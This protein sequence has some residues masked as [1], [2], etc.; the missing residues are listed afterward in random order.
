MR[1]V[2]LLAWYD[3]DPVWLREAVASA[4]GL[5]DE[6]VALDGAYKGFP[7]RSS[8]SSADQFDAIR[9]A[10]GHP[11]PIGTWLGC[12]INQMEKRTELFELGR[13]HD[14]DWFL[15]FDADDVVTHV[16]FDARDRL[17]HAN[18]DVG[19]FTLGSDRYHRGL[20][21]SLPNLRVEDA[22]YHYLAEKD[23]RTV[24]LR[25]DTNVHDLEG[26]VNL[27]DLKVAHRRDE[28]SP[29]R[30]AA[31]MEYRQRVSAEGIEAT[32]PEQWRRVAV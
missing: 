4:L 30:K 18:E 3:E 7:G 26:F 10:G 31:I 1:I 23:G 11:Y 25:G 14:A 24:H 27:T 17:E 5:C 9:E 13:E 8:R 20:F 21:R 22:H 32:T 19:V 12:W 2:G 28:R 29:E 16:P 15:V 6:V